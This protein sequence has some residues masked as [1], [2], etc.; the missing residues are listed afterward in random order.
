[1]VRE[2]KSLTARPFAVNV[3]VPIAGQDDL[4]PSP[5]AVAR[6]SARLR[7]RYEA[8]GLAMPDLAG[9][10]MPN[11]FQ[12]VDALL[13]AAPPVI[14]FVMGV[15][16]SSIVGEARRR[17][18][19]TIGTATTPDEAAALAS[20]GIDA[21]VASGSDA[22]GHR[23]SFLRSAESSFTGTFSLIPQ[24][25]RAVGVPVIAAGGISDGRG[26]AAALALGAEAVQLGTAFLATHESG[27]PAVHKKL[28]GTEAARWTRITRAFSGRHARGIEN[29]L[30]RDL[31]AHPDEVLH[32]PAQNALTQPLR[33]RAAAQGEPE[34]LA[35][36]A[37]QNAATVRALSANE[38][39]SLLV[40]ET[41]QAL[42]A[43]RL[44][45]EP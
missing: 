7:P 19:K 18:I 8:A 14:S 30:M 5:E 41:N 37:G 3:W 34:H 27:A 24:V 45:P 17:G 31:E 22:G 40:E 21:V 32:Y 35:L 10:L 11:F 16:D 43:P 26:I 9:E 1:L 36:W 12:Q 42:R 28:L 39:F 15:P 20:A 6:A 44:A 23:G 2:I 38:L 29:Q 25:A 13:A 4:R 33:K